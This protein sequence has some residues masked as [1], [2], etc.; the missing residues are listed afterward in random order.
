MFWIHLLNKHC[1]S[2]AVEENQKNP[3]VTSVYCGLNIKFNQLHWYLYNFSIL[4]I[5][6]YKSRDLKE[7]DKPFRNSMQAVSDW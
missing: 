1:P 7:H 3:T 4:C 2:C 6:C 5:H